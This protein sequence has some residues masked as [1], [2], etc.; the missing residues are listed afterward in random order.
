[1]KKSLSFVAL[2]ACVLAVAAA[3]PP[4]AVTTTRKSALAIGSG[5]FALVKGTKLEVVA[6]EGDTLL[7]KYRSSQGKIPLA[8]TDYPADVNEARPPE[9]TGAPVPSSA[10][11]ASTAKPAAAQPARSATPPA[12]NPGSQGQQPVTNYGKAVQKARQ[13]A[14]ASKS[15]HVDPTKGIMDEE[16]RK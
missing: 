4:S 8:D 14:E 12:V 13:A 15:S 7:V 2:L 5:S 16:P 3:P 11:M 10:P 6:R 1:M 9:P